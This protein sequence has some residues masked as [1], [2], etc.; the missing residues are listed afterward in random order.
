MN[1][2][3]KPYFYEHLRRLDRQILEIY[4]IT[5]GASQSTRTSPTTERTINPG[6]KVLLR[7]LEALGYTHI[8]T[9]GACEYVMNMHV[10]GS[11]L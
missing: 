8:C 9:Y 11:S 5:T 6:P 1:A 10:L 4:E 7:L 2:A 3:H